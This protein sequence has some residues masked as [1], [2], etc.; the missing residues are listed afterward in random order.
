MYIKI[1]NP[2]TNGK[3]A[4][5]NK[6]SARQATNYLEG[7]AKKQGETAVFFNAERADMSGDEAVELIDTNR[8]GLRK[9]DAKFYSLVIS[10]SAQ[11]LEH[12]GN[13]AQKLQHYTARVMQ[14]Y[15]ANFVTKS[16]QP[17]GEKDLVWVA[18]QHDERKHRG[19]D[20]APSGQPKEGPQTHIHIMVSARDKEQ[21]STLNPL[22]QATRFNRVNFMAKGNAAFE[23][24][25]GPGKTTYRTGRNATQEAGKTASTGPRRTS[26]TPEEIAESIRR[27][28]AINSGRETR[29]SRSFVNWRFYETPDQKRD[30]Q[31]FNEVDKLNKKLSPEQQLLHNKVLEAARAQD[32]SKTFYDRLGQLGREIKDGKSTEYPYE[33]LKTGKKVEPGKAAATNEKQEKRLFDQ[34]DRI[35]KKLPADKQLEHNM[36]LQI[37][38]EQD[39]SKAFY[40]RIGRINR[41]TN[42]QQY[43]GEPYEFLRTG[44][45]HRREQSVEDTLKKDLPKAGARSSDKQESAR[46]APQRPPR[47]GARIARNYQPSLATKVAGIGQDLGRALG[48]Q[49]YTQ[50]IRG[51]EERG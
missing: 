25:F 45:V 4:Y 34:V 37:A 11:E 24:E 32:Y 44:R 19:H 40:G 7:E 6:G 46:P 13:D 26:Q 29:T 27:K 28:A 51:D 22:G 18:T 36:V 42:N 48:T 49:G 33:F 20:G 14:E 21:K 50:D 12:I 31:L 16:G 9:D 3:N 1:I 47:A 10:P 15:A 39:F 35:N 5:S 38:R 17:L 41:E 2:A 30:K 43:K 23:E 8:K